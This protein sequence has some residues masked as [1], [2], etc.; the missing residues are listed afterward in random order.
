[1]LLQD[2]RAIK[3]QRRETEW[4]KGKLSGSGISSTDLEDGFS[5]RM[6]RVW[7]TRSDEERHST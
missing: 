4:P 2:I 3:D 7:K 5:L 6:Y 1:M